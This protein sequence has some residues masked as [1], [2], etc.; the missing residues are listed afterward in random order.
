MLLEARNLNVFYETAQVLNDSAI[1][2]DKGELVGLIGANGAGK[3][4]LLRH[5]SGLI[6]WEKE[7]KRGT[8]A[9]DITIEGEITFDGE[10][11]E[12]LP[13]YERARKGLILTPERGRPFPELSVYENIISGAYM[14]RDKKIIQKNLERVYQI[15]PL[16]KSRAKQVSGTLS[17]GERQQLALAR[18]LMGQPK[19]L[20]IDEPSTGLAPKLKEELFNRIK[21]IYELGISV[22]LTEQD[23]NFAFHLSNRNYL[24][25]AGKIVQE[26]TADELMQSEIVRKTYLGL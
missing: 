8:R 11:I 9:G 23:I 10:R 25:S 6:T 18:S 21:E 22:L 4:T 17:G 7:I 3:S 14:V 16:L 13:A 5:I 24:I 19:L 26:G 20:C 1:Q 12:N 15:F 2:V